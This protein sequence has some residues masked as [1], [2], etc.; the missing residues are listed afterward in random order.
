MPILPTPGLAA[1][2][3]LTQPQ[4]STFNEGLA[5]FGLIASFA[6][7]ALSAV[8]N[9]YAVKS[10][11]NV[12][13]SQALSA[14]FAS[15]MSAINARAAEQDAQAIT[16]AGNREQSRVSARYGQAK[17]AAR[18]AMAGRGIQAGV[19]S[20][21]EVQASIEHAKQADV[22]AV[23]SNAVRAAN[24][25]RTQAVNERNQSLLSGV[26]AANLRGTARTLD[27]YAAVAGS[28]LEGA[29]GIASQWLARTRYKNTR[30]GVIR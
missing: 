20:A 10:Q 5:N 7:T 28:L 14:E 19:G 15:S 2:G 3:A 22:F 6:S 25:A 12:L 21:A 29:S 30:A 4:A 9:F 26:S 23:N 13:K 1:Y 17:G 24:A 11:Q 18:A 8:G 27:P 16:E